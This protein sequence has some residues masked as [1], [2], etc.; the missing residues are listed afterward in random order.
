MADPLGFIGGSG[1]LG[2]AGF[3]RPDSPSHGAAPRDASGQ[4]FKDSLMS[5][6]DEANRLQQEADRAVEDLQTGRRNDVE[7]VILATQKADDAFRMLQALRNK[8]M[9]AYEEIKQMRT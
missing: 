9:E 1:G 8:M 4:T 3:P 7:G 6:L 2:G 5:N